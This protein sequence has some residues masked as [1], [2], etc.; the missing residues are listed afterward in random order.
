MFCV[1]QGVNARRTH[2]QRDR[3]NHIWSLSVGFFLLSTHKYLGLLL[4]INPF[5][6]KGRI[7]THTA[8]FL[9][10][11]RWSG[12]CILTSSLYL[13]G[14]VIWIMTPDHLTLHSHPELIH[15]CY[16]KFS[17]HCDRISL[18]RLS[19]LIWQLVNKHAWA[20][21]SW[22]TTATCTARATRCTV[23]RQLRHL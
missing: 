7:S 1:V 21:Y 13:S 11:G 23:Q 2:C 4:Q 3:P 5:I 12:P 15:S 18:C 10:K 20:W 8:T 16:C 19:R 6:S 17:L 9:P 22:G 14:Y